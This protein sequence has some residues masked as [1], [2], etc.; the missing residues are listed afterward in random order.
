MLSHFINEWIKST[1]HA[2]ETS[3]ISIMNADYPAFDLCGMHVL[4][5][6]LCKLQMLRFNF[7]LAA[8]VGCRTL[9]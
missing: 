4:W 3:T 9:Q 1:C 8:P 7:A 6:V 2:V 5:V